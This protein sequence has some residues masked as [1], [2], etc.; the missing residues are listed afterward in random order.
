MRYIYSTSQNKHAFFVQRSDFRSF[1]VENY[2][3]LFSFVFD[4][5]ACNH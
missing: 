3:A 5:S 1:F 2:R 4:W